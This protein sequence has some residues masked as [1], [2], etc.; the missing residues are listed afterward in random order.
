MKGIKSK[1]KQ[2]E[3]G[4]PMAHSSRKKETQKIK[5]SEDHQSKVPAQSARGL[6]GPPK[7]KPAGA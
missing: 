5:Q 4:K 1:N 7:E 3:S 2:E 6:P